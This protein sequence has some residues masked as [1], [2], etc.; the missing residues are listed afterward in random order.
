MNTYNVILYAFE[1]YSK[2][3]DGISKQDMRTWS[4][5]DGGFPGRRISNP[6]ITLWEKYIIF[7]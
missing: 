7:Q 2:Y 4:G 1:A 5:Q 3:S 6:N